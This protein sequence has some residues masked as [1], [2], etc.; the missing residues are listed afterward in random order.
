VLERDQAPDESNFENSSGAIE[1]SAGIGGG[2]QEV[3]EETSS[4]LEVN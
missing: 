3:V 1:N 2:T 4:Y